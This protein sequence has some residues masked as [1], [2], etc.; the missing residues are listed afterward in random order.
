VKDKLV[1]TSAVVDG[2]A[3]GYDY[4]FEGLIWFN[5]INQIQTNKYDIK[6]NEMKWKKYKSK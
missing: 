3:N 4:S 6:S 1:P 5:L 2:L